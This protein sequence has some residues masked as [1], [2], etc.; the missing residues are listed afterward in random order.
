MKHFSATYSDLRALVNDEHHVPVDILGEL[1]EDPLLFPDED[2]SIGADWP[3]SRA[4]EE[5]IER[6]LLSASLS[7]VDV[8]DIVALDDMGADDPQDEE[9]GLSQECIYEQGEVR[10]HT[11]FVCKYRRALGFRL[12]NGGVCWFADDAS[13]E[14]TLTRTGIYL[15][16][17]SD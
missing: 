15:A 6:L 5:G 4:G 12:P 3:V 13:D 10:P 17:T 7:R 14:S 11:C 2:A 1:Y 16:H 9:W 8:D